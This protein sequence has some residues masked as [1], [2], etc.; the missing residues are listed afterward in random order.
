MIYYFSATGNSQ[1]IAEQ[2]A[3]RT[4]D[5][6]VS[7]TD[8]VKGRAPQP[9]PIRAGETL[10]IVFPTYAW[11]TPKYVTKFVRKLSVSKDAFVYAI[12]TCE[13][14]V[15]SAFLWLAPFLHIDSRYALFM[16]NNF[17]VWGLG[18]NQE[19]YNHRVISESASKL[20]RIAAE[21]LQKKRSR[22]LP[23]EA[24]RLAKSF[25]IAPIFRL[26]RSDRKFYADD[27]CIGCGTCAEL[28]PISDISIKDGK[29]EWLH[30]HCMQCCACI[31]RCPVKAIQYGT[32]TTNG[33]RYVFPA[34]EFSGK[35]NGTD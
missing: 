7:M 17:A 14:E 3:A 25:V 2:I 16:P 9:A 26:T 32:A 6:A 19:S 18:A 22:K 1:W 34:A 35:A 4:N 11:S 33:V 13:A 5:T 15:G 29:P 21:I 30:K 20:D 24:L 8:V 27:K 31:N 10:G 23:A 12:A 28:C